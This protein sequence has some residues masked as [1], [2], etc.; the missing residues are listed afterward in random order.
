[1]DLISQTYYID[2]N[3]QIT[4]QVDMFHIHYVILGSPTGTCVTYESQMIYGQTLGHVF[5]I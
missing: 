1:M 2:T 4:C 3:G 5:V